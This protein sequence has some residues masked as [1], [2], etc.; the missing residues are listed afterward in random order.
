[1]R[2]DPDRAQSIEIR[3]IRRTEET[4]NC[5]KSLARWINSHHCAPPIFVP[6]GYW[7]GFR[8]FYGWRLKYETTSI[9][10]DGCV[11]EWVEACFRLSCTFLVQCFER[12]RR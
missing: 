12:R 9:L 6:N 10:F 7:L 1:M 5:E 3:E 11:V 8:L 4:V 2:Y